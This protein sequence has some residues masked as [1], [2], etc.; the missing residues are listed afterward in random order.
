MP[1]VNDIAAIYL[2]KF[3][4]SFK[5]IVH[6]MTRNFQVYLVYINVTIEKTWTYSSHLLFQI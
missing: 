3:S 2:D 6:K 1:R 5:K 4:F